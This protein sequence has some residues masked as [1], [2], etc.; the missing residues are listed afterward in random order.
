VA[1]EGGEREILQNVHRESL[2]KKRNLG[3]L[4]LGGRIISLKEIIL[5]DMDGLNLK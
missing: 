5:Q 3:D 4:S 1:R 2:K